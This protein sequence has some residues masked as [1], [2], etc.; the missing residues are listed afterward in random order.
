MGQNKMPG[1]FALGV[2]IDL[3][4]VPEIRR[5]TE[6]EDSAFLLRTFSEREREIAFREPDPAAFL[7]GRFAAKEAVFKAAAH[8]LPE[9]GFDFRLVETVR[10]ADGSPRVCLPEGLWARLAAVGVEDV[11]ISISG[12]GD[13]A[14][15]VAEA[16]G[17]GR[18][19]EKERRESG[20]EY[21]K[22]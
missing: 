9:K 19:D 4:Y 15:A 7:A 21:G 13:F 1:G 10:E 17:P 18:K 3:V 22:R 16:V 12:E 2:G 20:A 14:V 5:R 6:R 11:L 8:L